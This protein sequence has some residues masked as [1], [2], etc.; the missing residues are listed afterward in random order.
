MLVVLIEAVIAL[1]LFLVF[2]S[3]FAGFFS[4]LFSGIGW[5]SV[6]SQIVLDVVLFWISLHLSLLIFRKRFKPEDADNL[7]LKLTAIYFC[8]WI[9]HFFVSS[10]AMNDFLFFLYAASAYFCIKLFFIRRVAV[11]TKTG[12]ETVLS[13]AHKAVLEKLPQDHHDGA[14]APIERKNRLA[15]RIAYGLTVLV[16]LIAYLVPWFTFDGQVVYG[17]GALLV[18]SLPYCIGLIIAVVL[19]FTGSTNTKLPMSAARLMLVGVFVTG[20]LVG[21]AMIVGQIANVVSGLEFSGGLGLALVVSFVYCSV[22]PLAAP[23][24]RKEKILIQK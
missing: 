13:V 8:V 3:F 21:A 5:L 1:P 20:A 12:N 2:G 4:A 7:A 17:I 10:S 9:V 19:L 22:G 18:F 16:A 23:K 6:F 15:W 24:F 11:K 14:P